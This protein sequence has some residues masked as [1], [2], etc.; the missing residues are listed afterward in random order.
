MVVYTPARVKSFC[1]IFRSKLSRPQF[2]N[3]TMLLTGI[4]FATG[5]RS[6]AQFGRTIAGHT[7]YRGT[8][9]RHLK[10]RFLRTR[11]L[12]G[13]MS[14]HLVGMVPLKRG[15][16]WVLCID[17][18]STQRGSFTKIANAM[19]FQ[20]KGPNSRGPGSKAHTFVM[21]LLITDTGMRIPLRRMTWRTK[22]YARKTNKKYKT[23]T[24]LAYALIEEARALVPQGIELIIVA[25]GYFGVRKVAQ[26][27]NRLNLTYIIPLG[28][29][30]TVSGH[31]NRRTRIDNRARRLRRDVWEEFSLVSGSEETVHYRRYS[32]SE[33]EK[34][35]RRSYRVYSEVRN[36]L[37]LG[38]V[39]LTYSWKSRIYT[40][41][42]P[43]DQKSL[44]FLASNN[45]DLRACEMVELYELRWQIELFFRELKSNLGLGDFQGTDF[46]AFERYVDLVLLSFMCLEWSRLIESRALAAR[47]SSG[48]RDYLH[49]KSIEEDFVQL[50]SEIGTASGR[51]RFAALLLRTLGFTNSPSQLAS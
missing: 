23:Q 13:E 24:D 5:K 47:R 22:S 45:H 21:G 51:R 44:K 32:A 33:R 12:C 15:A 6:M 42:G 43:R 46:Q 27:C 39:K 30:R 17:G 7:R 2:S 28:Q 49:A 19:Q 14:R 9:S 48:I 37:T 3:L 26:C 40:S 20:K 11:D 8:I 41:R 4:L 31:D 1:E 36:L 50:S 38:E 18:V 29:Q 34:S 10:S 16:R 25:D 35:K